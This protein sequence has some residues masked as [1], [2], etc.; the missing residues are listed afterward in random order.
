MPPSTNN[1]LLT[2]FEDILD[3]STESG[4][5]QYKL[6]T[7]PVQEKSKF[8][9]AKANYEKWMSL[10][11]ARLR[12]FNLFEALD[13]VVDRTN[14][15]GG[16]LITTRNLLTEPGL[17]KARDVT[18]HCDNI[19]GDFG[20][21]LVPTLELGPFDV[22]EYNLNRLKKHIALGAL[23]FDSCTDDF[24]SEMLVH[25][26]KFIREGKTCGVQFLLEIQKKV[27]PATKVSGSNLKTELESADLAGFDHNVSSLLTFFIKTRKAIKFDTGDAAYDE[28][29]RLFFSALENSPSDSFNQLVTTERNDWENGVEKNLVTLG[30]VVVRKYNNLTATGQWKP[31][32][33]KKNLESKVVAMQA[34]IDNLEK[35]ATQNNNQQGNGS[36]NPPS[37][38]NK[39]KT[40]EP[41]KFINETG[42]L[43]MTND[44]GLWYSCSKCGERHGKTM[45]WVKHK[46][47]E[48]K[49][50][51]K[52]P[53][54]P[55]SKLTVN[56]DLKVAMQAA[57]TKE[58]VEAVLTQF[59]L[60]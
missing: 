25:D 6:M 19:W 5:S 3:F 26:D 29:V 2:P 10:I 11:A 36:G 45:M 55:P 41:W 17:I 32:A 7:K 9:G 20:M 52:G 39:R 46:P 24:Q 8:D 22:Y 40:P 54:K 38:K 56:N 14:M 23:L 49:D 31:T 16:L 50:L 47:E 21:Q 13:I 28:Y 15:G 37:S 60:N 48:H 42:E 1:R 4:K 57:T 18:A 53:G 27:T 58:E 12:N 59:N 43:T 51:S 34:T 35:K 33:S 30:E 44:N